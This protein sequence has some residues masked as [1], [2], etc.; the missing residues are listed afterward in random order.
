[1]TALHYNETGF[2]ADAFLALAQRVWPRAYDP[3]RTAAALA[4]TINIGAYDGDRLVGAVRV[5]TDGYFF[6]AVPDILVEPAY[7]RRGIGRELLRRAVARAPSGKVFFGA[8][9]QSVS[10]FE[11]LGCQRGPEGFV[12]T[13]EQF[14]AGARASAT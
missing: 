12:A 5:L 13:Q 14:S 10:F 7:Q 6:A 4:R 1:M 8:Q 9:P 11:R 2:P 3:E